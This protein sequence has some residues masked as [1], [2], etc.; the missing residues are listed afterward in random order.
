MCCANI[1]YTS[2]E[3][4][5]NPL[6]V[7]GVVFNVRL[8]PPRVL[9]VLISRASFCLESFLWPFFQ[10][11]SAGPK[12]PSIHFKNGLISP[13]F[14]MGIFMDIEY[15]IYDS[16]P[17]VA[18]QCCATSSVA[19]V[20]KDDSVIVFFLHWSNVVSFTASRTYFFKNLLSFSE[21]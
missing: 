12:F 9:I 3:D 2:Q 11:R 10:G 18:E 17:V 4:R 19:T 13:Q 15:W 1:M 20:E 21:V 7:C 6:H 5:K 14:L 8:L 16:F